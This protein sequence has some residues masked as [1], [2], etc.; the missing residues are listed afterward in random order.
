MSVKLSNIL[1]GHEGETFYSPIIGNCTLYEI[2]DTYIKVQYL[3]NN[4]YCFFLDGRREHSGECM[5]FPSK[6][7]RDWDKWDKENNAKTPKTWSELVKKDNRQ[8]VREAC[9]GVSTF[10]VTIYNS[11]KIVKSVLAFLKIRR[12]IEISYGGNVSYSD[13]SELGKPDPV[14]IVPQGTI[15][16]GNIAFYA[17]TEDVYDNSFSHI[18]FHTKEQAQEFLSHEENIQLLKDYFMI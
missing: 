9:I 17:K 6:Y 16:S 18:A 8:V 11:P 1:R 7:Q 13:F 3:N 4:Y 15:P 2:S 10:Q 12:L 5:L 14:I